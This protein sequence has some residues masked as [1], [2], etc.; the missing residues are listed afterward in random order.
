MCVHYP[1]NSTLHQ[2]SHWF[3]LNKIGEMS[4][5]SNFKLTNCLRL[6][7]TSVTIETS[8]SFVSTDELSKN[9]SNGYYHSISI[10]I[11][12]VYELA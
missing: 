11:L 3:L 2:S 9:K 1:L 12:T 4:P 5:R 10:G 6:Y 8:Q 7:N